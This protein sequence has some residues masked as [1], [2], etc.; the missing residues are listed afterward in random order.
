ML[1]IVI[2]G[3]VPERR[4]IPK[5]RF[6]HWPKT[7]L[8]K[9]IPA[10]WRDF[11]PKICGNGRSAGRGRPL[12]LG[13]TVAVKLKHAGFFYTTLYRADGVDG[14][15][16]IERN[17]ATAK[18]VAWPSCAWLLLNSFPF[19]VGHHPIRPVQKSRPISESLFSKQASLVLA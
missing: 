9:N 6:S 14:P 13:S 1:P 3:S 12:S 5:V 7:K 17:L 11:Q 15:Q 16:E 2:G 19:P 18:H 8:C 4:T 10:E